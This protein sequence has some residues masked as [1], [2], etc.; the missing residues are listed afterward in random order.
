MSTS[1]ILEQQQVD[2]LNNVNKLI[3]Q[4]S[5]SILCDTNCQHEKKINEAKQTYINAQKNLKTAPQQLKKAKL[6]YITI[7]DGQ[8][9]AKNYIL[10]EATNEANILVSTTK[11]I[12]D[13][14]MSETVHLTNT[15]KSLF[16]NFQSITELY[17]KYL[18]ENFKILER[19]N[20]LN[21]DT[22]TNDRK[23]YYEKQGYSNLKWWYTFLI[24]TYFISIFIFALCILLS[25]SR[26]GYIKNIIILFAFIIY[27]FFINN[28]IL[29][30]VGSITKALRFLP[31]NAYTTL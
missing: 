8:S 21:S 6:D 13:K 30:V 15:Y 20:S 2:M 31:K 23:S 29:F 27:P 4:S 24:W 5:D 9:K 17:K 3:K 16:Y 25:R 14:K 10:E 28:I 1:N 7:L 22:I 26:Y 12:F 18:E 11:E 19:I